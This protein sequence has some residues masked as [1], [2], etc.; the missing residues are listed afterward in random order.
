MSVAKLTALLQPLVTELG[1]EFVG[2]EYSSNP[3]NPVLVLYIDK[4]EGIAVEDCETVSRE[5]AAL[6][7]V[8]DPIPGHYVLEVS[9][10]GLDRPL[11]TPEQFERFAGEVA[12]VS[13]FAPVSGRRK[14]KGRI[15]GVDD[16]EIRIEQDGEAIVLEH[17][18]IAKARLVPDYDQIFAELG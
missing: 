18:N 13:V 1:F 9:S 15:L 5:A 11:F 3:K 7:D 8:E 14:F 6:L 12:Q 10:P 2:L 16:S 17:G 4:P